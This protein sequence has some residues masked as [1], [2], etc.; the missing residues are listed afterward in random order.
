MID[1]QSEMFSTLIGFSLPLL[2]AMV[3]AMWLGYL[4]GWLYS[5][6]S[7]RQGSAMRGQ[8][9]ALRAQLADTEERLAATGRVMERKLLEREEEFQKE[10][11][12]EEKLLA[13]LNNQV[14][15]L[16]MALVAAQR[17]VPVE[18]VQERLVQDPALLARL[19]ELETQVLRNAELERELDELRS[20]PRKR[21]PA[22]GSAPL[23]KQVY[24][25]MSNTFGKR[26]VPNDLQLVE[27]IGPKI[28]EHLKKSGLKT[29]ADV[30]AV[31]PAELRKVLAEGG[32]RFQMHDPSHWP[33]QAKLMAENRWDELRKYQNKLAKS[34]QKV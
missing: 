17:V 28:Q 3:G 33:T 7:D 5:P 10:R 15:T 31:K 18:E 32:E 21:T 30:A 19:A 2:L 27:G 6:A 22:A 9:A 12:E 26:I 34:K 11:T 23:P 25:V 8:L 29:W 20:A 16:K 14:T 24:N 4:F 1:P 13:H